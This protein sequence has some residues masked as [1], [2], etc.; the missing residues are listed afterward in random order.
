MS[1]PIGKS[2][3]FIMHIISAQRKTKCQTGNERVIGWEDFV[4][5]W[6]H[7]I[8]RR[9]QTSRKRQLSDRP[10]SSWKTAILP[11]VDNRGNLQRKMCNSTDAACSEEK[12]PRST[13]LHISPTMLSWQGW[14]N[15]TV[16][17]DLNKKEHIL[18]QHRAHAMK[19]ARKKTQIE[20]VCGFATS[21]HT[22]TVC[23]L[24]H[25]IWLSSK[26]TDYIIYQ[27]YCQMFK[28]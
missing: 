6:I 8:R 17:N 27:S 21:R 14:W 26:S 12:W 28:R 2:F 25:E 9:Q 11:I 10:V 19:F 22:S 15:C 7:S 1:V 13:Y 18:K 24:D 5:I 20:N 4:Y 23:D 3:R 16:Q